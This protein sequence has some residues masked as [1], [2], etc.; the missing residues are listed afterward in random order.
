[1]TARAAGWT[2]LAGL[3]ACAAVSAYEPVVVAVPDLDATTFAVVAQVVRA[4]YP[5]LRVCDPAGFRL[6]SDWQAHDAGAAPGLRRVTVFPLDGSAGSRLGLVVE[7]SWL[8][9][10]LG[11]EPRWTPVCGA[12][13]LEA[14]L[15][16][17][18]RASFR[19]A[20]DGG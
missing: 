1:M 3:A 10:G 15:A 4:R 14:E 6:Q 20:D 18:I 19:R 17:A 8:H 11:G 12:A 2:A 9:L 5:R 16:A 7:V 13:D